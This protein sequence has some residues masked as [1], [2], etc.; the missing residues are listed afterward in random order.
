MPDELTIKANIGP[1]LKLGDLLAVEVGKALEKLSEE[2][3]A[4]AQGRCPVSAK[5]SNDNPPGFL[6][7]SISGTVT[8]PSL[9]LKAGAFYAGYVEL[10]TRRMA[11]RPFLTPAV[12]QAEIKLPGLLREAFATAAKA[13]R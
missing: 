2:T 11:A 12:D 8:G 4:D 10:G 3:V 6:R 1:L 5:G 9:I 13:A 7:D